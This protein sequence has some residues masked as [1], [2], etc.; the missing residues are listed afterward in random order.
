MKSLA[1]L[2][3]RHVVYLVGLLFLALVL[4][5]C[6]GIDLGDLVK[7]KTPNAIQQTTGLRSTLSLNE[8]EVEYQQW[9][10]Q[11]QATGAQWKSNID[12]SGEVRGLLGQ[13]T[14]SALDTVGPTVAGLPVL[15]PALPALTGI[16]G[17]FIGSGRLRK[18][19][20]AS[21]NKGLET[22]R[23]MSEA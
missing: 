4:A 13:L 2:S 19:K 21:F 23:D 3:T 14:L 7:V 22:G 8:A 18:E 9:F 6:A 10:N 15:G 17:L 16:V 12:R 20:E 11:V 1:P 5:S